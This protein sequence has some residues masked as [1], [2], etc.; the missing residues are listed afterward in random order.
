LQVGRSLPII[1]AMR[2]AVLVLAGLCFLLT[3]GWLVLGLWLPAAVFVM[4]GFVGLRYALRMP[5]RSSS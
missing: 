5:S 1:G 2:L 3:I 4:V